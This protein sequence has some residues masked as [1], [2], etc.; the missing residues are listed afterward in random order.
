MKRYHLAL[1]GALILGLIVG[2]FALFGFTTS[3]YAVSSPTTPVQPR[4]RASSCSL[5]ATKTVSPTTT[6]PNSAVTVTISLAT[7]GECTPQTSPVDMMILIDQSLSMGAKFAEV[8]T[9]AK[10]LIGH[11]DLQ[12]DQVGIAGFG[13]GE[14]GS[15]SILHNLSDDGSALKQAIDGMATVGGGAKVAEGLTTT[16]LEFQSTRHVST[17]LP[18]IVLFTDAAP[19]AADI[20]KGESLR[21]QGVRVVTVALGD[22]VYADQWQRIATAPSDA[23]IA[24]D[25]ATIADTIASKVRWSG[26]EV[27][28]ND[29]LSDAVLLIPTSVKS[30]VPPTIKDNH[31]SLAYPSLQTSESVVLSYRAVVTDTLGTWATNENAT[32]SYRDA[33]GTMN[34]PDLPSPKVTVE[35]GCG[36]P[37]LMSLSPTTV[38]ENANDVSMQVIGSGMTDA[39]RMQLGSSIL[40]DVQRIDRHTFSAIYPGGLK[41]G[42][43]V[44]SATSGCP[45]A[46]TAFLH[47]AVTV[48]PKPKILSVRPR[49]G[50]ADLDTTINICGQHFTE[51]TKVFLVGGGGSV[52]LKDV[53]RY[54]DQCLAAVVP[55]YYSAIEYT[56]RVE[57]PYGNYSGGTYRVLSD[58]INNDLWAEEPWISPSI[59]AKET[60]AFEMGLFVH[61]RGGKDTLMNV[62]VRF[63][64]DVVDEAHLIGDGTIP[65]L[66]PRVSPDDRIKGTS[67]TAVSWTPSKGDDVYTIYAVIDPEKT[68]TEDIEDN[69][70]VSRTVRVLP[71]DDNYDGVPPT[72]ADMTISDDMLYTAKSVVDIDL[73][74]TDSAQRYTDPSGV[75][76]INLVE[77][78]YSRAADAWVPV[79]STGWRPYTTD[80]GVQNIQTVTL[81]PIPGAHYIQAWVSDKNGNIERHPT[82]QYI[83]Y[84]ATCTPVEEFGTHNYLQPLAAGDT[85]YV[86]LETCG[87]DA[88]LYVWPPDWDD[89]ENPRPPWVSNA[90]ETATEVVTFTAP[91]EGVYLIETYGAVAKTSYTLNVDRASASS[92]ALTH[93]RSHLSRTSSSHTSSD[94][95][96]A[97]KPASDKF[98]R[99]QPSVPASSTPGATAAGVPLPPLV[100]D[101]EPYRAPISSVAIEG[102]RTGMVAIA[103]TFKAVVK[104]P[105]AVD[106]SIEYIWSPMPE[107]QGNPEAV[108]TWSSTGVHTVTVSVKNSVNEMTSAPHTITVK[109]LPTIQFH[110][111]EQYTSED[112]EAITVTVTMAGMPKKPALVR[113]QTLDHTARSNDDYLAQDGVLT[114]TTEILT[115][116]FTVPLIDDDDVE[117]VE[118]FNLSLSNVEG[119]AT[120]GEPIE[121]TVHIEDNEESPNQRGTIFFSNPVMRVNEGVLSTTVTISRTRGVQGEVTIRYDTFGLTAQAGSD[122]YGQSGLFVFK[123]GDTKHDIIIPIIDDATLEGDEAI[124]LTLQT[125]AGGAA[126]GTQS[127][128]LLVIEDNDVAERGVIQFRTPHTT[129]REGR[130]TTDVTVERIGK[131]DT[132]VIVHYETIDATARAREDYVRAHGA[133]F[134]GV[135]ETRKTIPLLIADDQ[136][137]EGDEQFSLLLREVKGAATIGA[138]HRLAITIT[139]DDTSPTGVLQFGALERYAS[140]DNG[141]VLLPVRRT[142]GYSESITAKVQMRER[143]ARAGEDY[144][145]ETQTLTFAS[146]EK[147]QLIAVSLINDAELEGTEAFYLTL[148][149][150]S[151]S[152]DTEESHIGSQSEVKLWI[153]DD[154][155]QPEGVAQF[156][157]EMWEVHEDSQSIRLPVERIGGA[158]GMA[159]LSYKSAPLTASESDYTPVQGN[160]VFGD[161]QVRTFITVPI[162]DDD[163]LEGDETFNVTLSQP[164]GGIALGTQDAAVVS[165]LDTDR[166]EDEY[167]PNDQCGGARPIV[168]NTPAQRHTFVPLA[169]DDWVVL[170]GVAETTY[171]IRA[172]A[173]AKSPLNLSLDLYQACDEEPIAHYD[174]AF[175]RNVRFSH[176]PAQSGPLYLKVTNTYTGTFPKGKT[177]TYE[178]EVNRAKTTT[179]GALVIVAGKVAGTLQSNIDAVAQRVYRVFQRQGYSDEHITYLSPDLTKAGADAPPT[180]AALETALT[181]WAGG[182]VGPDR[183]LILY[184]IG[185]TSYDTL[186]LDEAGGETV[187]VEDLADWLDQLAGEHPGTPI[188]VVGEGNGTGSLIDMPHTVSALGRVVIGATGPHTIAY[189]SR[190]GA[191]F[192]DFF[193]S[194]LKRGESVAQS[195][196]HAKQVVAVF[197]DVQQPMIDTNGNSIANEQDDGDYGENTVT[198]PLVD[199]WPPLVSH[200]SDT[201]KV[202]RGKGAIWAYI[203]D[204]DTSSPLTVWARVVSP[205]NQITL[206]SDPFT[207][208]D[209]ET[210]PLQDEDGDGWFGATYSGFTANGTYRITVGAEDEDG[211]LA[212]PESVEVEVQGGSG[213]SGVE[214]LYLPVVKR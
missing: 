184:F 196:A 169:E 182:H 13:R 149:D 53:T 128:A 181:T 176:K 209:A 179:P 157:Q 103:D 125:V 24:T 79:N 57:T 61:R 163:I 198:T 52:E 207:Q 160:V 50:Y 210:A 22:A 124:L 131:S 142:G 92:P 55:A 25:L 178:L 15:T 84:A 137:L 158:S 19:T 20:A 34:R 155:T 213:S 49:E 56:V 59:S 115:N 208:D 144:T 206:A 6:T 93:I 87:G 23:Y 30:P 12:H 45:T 63:Y 75:S 162:S 121:S 187:S 150:D 174:P 165:I 190:K 133:L 201:L 120:L 60:E 186:L 97:A 80:Q 199:G 118:T 71:G 66:S 141:T 197:T 1:V 156:R 100:T 39:V 172:A 89:A 17:T 5:E 78:F 105:E 26:L 168:S 98:L 117:G 145:D 88:D 159:T 8:Q 41:A 148:H 32:A 119:G 104:P 94:T 153:E 40:T 77:M 173:P 58:A 152:G 96:V 85:L 67:T 188:I 138:Q 76:S 74:A 42:T 101:L 62:A 111:A 127:S 194:A 211:L 202:E 170:E 2:L 114:F 27:G 95:E 90:S 35:E 112:E 185:A 129:V 81:F 3:A 70:V 107:E 214:Y 28:I 122:Y 73:K 191:L 183:P 106:E 65:M 9:A 161:G 54:G 33:S 164:Q 82:Q 14:S 68:I 166:P 136:Q 204:D 72:V 16:A 132:P 195:F 123:A 140:E 192:S 36:Q 143:S 205:T 175:S 139:D 109:A 113:Y 69:N 10:R 116:T 135:G 44:L 110:Q 180:A 86:S 38:C 203:L 151:A 21:Q 91:V 4:L 126:Q 11:L 177:P 18:L 200:L 83:N 171:H 7:A 193:L 43:H 147:E 99:S 134:F 31:I 46:D 154:E 29:P 108:Y 47:D 51:G 212:V 167:E 146:G 37:Q 130:R 189:P 64:E 48:V 102:P